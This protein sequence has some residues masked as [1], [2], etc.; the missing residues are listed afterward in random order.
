[1][2]GAIAGHWLLGIP[3]S[4]L[5]VFGIIALAGVVVNDSLILVDFVNRNRK[6]GQSRMEAAIKATRSRFRAIILTS[7][8]TFL[9]LAPIIFFE[10]SLQAQLVVPMA[11]SLA[12]GILF[13]TAITLALIPILYLIVEDIINLIFRMVGADRNRRIAREA[14]RV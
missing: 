6:A 9:G 7:M 12:F 2:V 14:R 3:I 1:M 13:A 11:T 5:S 10:T 8:T 4:M